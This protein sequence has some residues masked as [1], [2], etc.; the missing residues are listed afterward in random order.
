MVRLSD[1]LETETTLALAGR[2]NLM[3]WADRGLRL[4]K[5]GP[6]R[7]LLLF[8]ITGERGFSSKVRKRAIS[9]IRSHGGFYTGTL[10]G[11]M[12]QKGR[13]LTPYLRNTLWDLGYAVDTL[14]TAVTWSQVIQTKSAII[15]ALTRA[16]EE[17]DQG[18]LAFAHL[19]H[20]YTDGASI[21][22]T[23]LFRR[24]VDP[25]ETLERWR[26]MKREAS[27]V[28]L[29][30]RGT[31]SH[32]HGIGLDHLPYMAI[33]KGSIGLSMLEVIQRFSDPD[34]IM[35]PGKLLPDD[36]DSGFNASDYV[37]PGLA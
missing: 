11:T 19:S 3:M 37:D 1:P 30:H 20:V 4:L 5:F 16:R 18:M 28:I 8:G 31:I 34:Q 27:L 6:E 36:S 10:V 2:E 25:D 7:C 14:E 26:D 21:Y 22:A 33:E 9:I 12:W 32:Q 13:F 35:N 17:R 15:E 29:K 23:Y 24:S